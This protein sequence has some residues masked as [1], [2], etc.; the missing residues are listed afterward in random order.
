[1]LFC[2]VFFFFVLLHLIWG[3]N[4]SWNKVSLLPSAE[5]GFPRERLGDRKNLGRY[6][7][8]TF[9][10]VMTEPWGSLMDPQSGC[11]GIPEGKAYE[12]CLCLSL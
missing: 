2:F 4:F 10:S 1:M 7:V 8:P 12:F 3:K 6:T 5:A 9:S 11:G